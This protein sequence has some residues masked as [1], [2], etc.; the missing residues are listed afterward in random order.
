MESPSTID[1]GTVLYVADLDRVT[2]TGR[3]RH[4][5]S[6]QEVSD[7]AALAIVKYDSDSGVYLFYCDKDWNSVTDTY[8]ENVDR[9]IEQAEFEFGSLRFIDVRRE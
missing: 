1:G 8:H 7:F 4:V 3:T 6:G 2:K 9:A 5:V